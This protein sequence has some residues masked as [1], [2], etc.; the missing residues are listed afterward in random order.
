MKV[1]DDQTVETILATTGLR[2]GYCLL[3]G[4]DLGEFAIQIALNI[5]DA[6]YRRDAGR[7]KNRKSPKA[8]SSHEA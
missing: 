8:A 1:S 7:C 4:D 2:Q 3:L 6:S 5:R